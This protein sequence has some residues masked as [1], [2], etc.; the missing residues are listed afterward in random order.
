MSPIPFRRNATAGSRLPGFRSPA[1]GRRRT[2]ARTRSPGQTASKAGMPSGVARPERRTR[3]GRGGRTGPT[4][5]TSSRTT[6]QP[7]AL[8]DT[9]TTVPSTTHSRGSSRSAR[10]AAWRSSPMLPT[11]AA[12]ASTRAAPQRTRKTVR[13]KPRATVPMHNADATPN[14]PRSA[15][16]IP[17]AW[18]ASNGTRE[19]LR[20]TPEGPGVPTIARPRSVGHTRFTQ[21]DPDRLALQLLRI[22]RIPRRR[23]SRLPLPPAPGLDT[24]LA[25]TAKTRAQVVLVRLPT[26]RRRKR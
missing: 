18:A 26:R 2:S 8:R 20:K 10:A 1:T 23:P 13:P 9:D 5:R 11:P 25:E 6:R 15:Q 7:W 17:A 21:V 14:M 3:R 12:K 22:P 19:T 4:P 24:L 16:R